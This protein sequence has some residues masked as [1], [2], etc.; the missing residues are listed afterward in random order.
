MKRTA[1]ILLSFWPILLLAQNPVWTQFANS[2]GGTARND[3]IFFAN[4]T[5]GWSARGTDGVYR[6]TNGGQN[7]FKVI[8][9][10]NPVAHFRCIGFA[11]AT[12]GWAGNLGPGS[13]DS[14]V[15]DTNMLYE[16]F[17]GGM[18]WAPVPGI[19]ASG[20]EGFCAL[21]VMDAQH[22]YGAGRVRGRAYFAKTENA[23]TNWTVV[24]L[25]D[26]GV[27]GGLMDVY[28][29]DATNGF[30]VG[31]DT[32]AYNTTCAAPFYH[33]AIARTTNGGIS[34]SVVASTPVNCSY[35]WKMSWP[36]PSIGYASLQQNSS[37]NTVVFYKTVDG[38]ATW[39]SNGI[40]LSA[41][42]SPASFGLQ[43][44]GF[45][46]TNEGWM[47]GT[48]VL[49]P[50]YSFIHTTNGGLT[51]TS[52]GYTNTRSINRIRFA[53]PALGYM[54]G[55]ALHVYH[56]PLAISV[57]PTNQ[58]VNPGANVTFTASAY[59]TPP[60]QFQW[61]FNGTNIAGAT[62]NVLNVTNVQSGKLGSYD[63]LVGDFS[64][65]VTSSVALTFTG[66]LLPPAVAIQPKSRVVNLNSNAAFSVT[67]S[68]SPPLFFQ[69]YFNGMPILD[70][71]GSSF[72][73]TN[74][75]LSDAGNYS[76]VVTNF[77]GRVA[78]DEAAL[79]FGFVEDFEQYASAVVVTNAGSTNRFKLLFGAVAGGQDF[80]A[81]FGFDYSTFSFPL[82]IPPAPHS[83]TGSTRGLFLAVN[84]DA[85]G[86]AAAVNLY[87]L[88]FTNTGNFS[89]K[90]DLWLNWTNPGSATEHALFGIN[91]S[92]SVTNRI[93]QTNS[94]GLF[95]AVDGDGNV[96]GTSVLV[97]DFAV[98][99]GGGE[100][101]PP[102]LLLTNTTTFGPTPPWGGRFDNSD[103][104]FVTLFPAKAVPG[105][106][107]T[108]AGTPGL[109]WVDVEVRQQNYLVTCLLN[110]IAIAQYTNTYGY[111]SGVC[112][113][114]YNDAFDS[115]G[116]TNN[117]AVF[118]NIRI[119]EIPSV[120]F[121]SSSMVGNG[122]NLNF[123]TVPYSS[124]TLQWTTNLAAP[125]WR[126]H[127]NFI[128]SGT[129]SSVTV[130][131]TSQLNQVYF[132]I[133]QP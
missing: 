61:R 77:L 90:F 93:G 44:I 54:S 63:V 123:T 120:R 85:S 3:D 81:V 82:P 122:F 113:I 24:K 10:I 60:L 4:Q 38:G 95:F 121:F 37:Y 101:A 112:M 80:K 22:I 16:T 58:A 110:G 107:S 48:T 27:M 78:S 102:V 36:S 66:G 53:Q 127:T 108:P 15:N 71:T 130:P 25:T 29:K 43:G 56:V 83:T 92:A 31:M 2:P 47:G 67:A 72:V 118:D 23:G 32:N 109:G 57:A 114:G 50:P 96:S 68:G 79:T 119:E 6:T 131:M 34:W 42:G 84:K 45:V 115:A 19:N 7:W 13:Y 46:S 91:H 89:L 86:A 87:P 76:V 18:T 124:Y 5:N 33:G 103:S 62:N 99:R 49:N 97:R 132:R 21:H 1:L 26:A 105:Y 41:I 117:F 59:G 100:G 75:Q 128:A 88:N 69:W 11:S 40:P 28:F 125:D 73:R 126:L 20:M 39:T 55:Q 70:A 74:A 30:V 98:F 35:F 8:P 9:N 52:E 129:V 106:P 14:S 116:S 133:S 12:R 64:G 51:W 65:V 111:N 17:D 104:G 94:D